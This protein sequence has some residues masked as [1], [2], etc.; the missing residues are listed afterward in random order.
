MVDTKFSRRKSCNCKIVTEQKFSTII[1]NCKFSYPR[2]NLLC[3]SISERVLPMPFAGQNH[4][5]GVKT[6]FSAFFRLF[7]SFSVNKCFCF[8]AEKNDFD[9]PAV[10]RAP[11]HWSK[12][13]TITLPILFQLQFVN[14]QLLSAQIR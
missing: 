11:V 6:S 1:I 3:I 8:Y 10:C 7:P 14:K 5:F 12:Y 13:T 2:N 9:Q 4:F